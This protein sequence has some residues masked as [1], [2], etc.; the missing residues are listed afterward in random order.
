MAESPEATAR[1]A[2][3]QAISLICFSFMTPMLAQVGEELK[4]FQERR[5]ETL[6]LLAGGPHASADPEGCMKLGFDL[7]FVGESEETLPE[8]IDEILEQGP[9][10]ARARPIRRG[11]GNA[12]LDR[13]PPF[14]VPDKLFGPIEIQR[15]CLYG[16]TYCQVPVLNHG[17]VRERSLPSLEAYVGKAREAG[18]TRVKFLASNALGYGSRSPGKPDADAIGELLRICRAQGIPQVAY[19]TFPSETRPDYVDAA[20]LEAVRS[21]A[22]NKTIVVGIQ[23]GSD[24][25]LRALHRGHTVEDGIRAVRL[26]NEHGFRAYVDVLFSTPGETVEDCRQSL[27][28]MEMLLKQ[29]HAKIHAHTFMPLPGNPLW[30]QE[31]SPLPDFVRAKLRDFRE[32]GLLD[33]W[34]EEQEVIAR[35]IL[36]WKKEGLIRA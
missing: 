22:S 29:Y 20:V 25:V 15:G 7:V 3:G 18:F 24:R 31:P 14:S 32:N 36:K 19:G 11:S 2:G 10:S 27:D 5:S 21:H 23:S 28:L 17:K 26:L 13:Y 16:C 4:L 30:G 8:A 35:D 33:G 1:L 34:W 9:A 12:D 6:M